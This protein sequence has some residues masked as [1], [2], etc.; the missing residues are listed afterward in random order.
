[1]QSNTHRFYSSCSHRHLCVRL[2]VLVLKVLNTGHSG[3]PGE[4]RA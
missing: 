4:A 2:K 1:M 3:L